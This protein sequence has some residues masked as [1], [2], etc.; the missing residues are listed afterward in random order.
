M[1]DHIGT[2][3]ATYLRCSQKLAH[4]LTR[5]DRDARAYRAMEIRVAA[6]VGACESVRGTLV[7]TA[8]RLEWF[9]CGHH[10]VDAQ[11]IRIDDALAFT[12]KPDAEV[13]GVL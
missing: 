8:D 11:L 9:G 4:M 6:L 13:L 5:A 12:T 2:A 10:E 1:N 7:N 3:P